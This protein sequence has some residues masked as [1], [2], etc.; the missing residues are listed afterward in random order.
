LHTFTAEKSRLVVKVPGGIHNLNPNRGMQAPRVLKM[1]K[2]DFV[3]QIKVTGDFKPGEK[4]A[5]NQRSSFNGAGLLVWQD[6]KN[7]IR[8]ERNRWYVPAAQ[9]YACYPPLLEY[10]KNGEYQ[11]TGLD[12][13][14]DEFFK[15][16]STWLRLERKDVPMK[17]K[18][19]RG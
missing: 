15:G 8:L 16:R 1:V 12:S 18:C 11:D 5:N 4:A 2:G 19:R 6:E 3:A 14:L 9:K 17:V 10:H 13:T 7:Y